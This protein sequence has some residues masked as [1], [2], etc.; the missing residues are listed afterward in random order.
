[1][2]GVAGSREGKKCAVALGGRGM[3]EGGKDRVQFIAVAR[4]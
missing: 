2:I 3:N 4:L 1:M